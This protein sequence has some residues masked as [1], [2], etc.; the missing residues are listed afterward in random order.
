V[1]FV[2]KISFSH[3][4]REGTIDFPHVK[5]MKA[6]SA[7]QQRANNGPLMGFPTELA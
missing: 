3:A 6:A 2:V 4:A 1:F 5:E 7:G